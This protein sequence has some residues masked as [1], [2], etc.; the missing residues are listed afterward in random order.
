M[1]TLLHLL[2]APNELL[3]LL[4]RIP[5]STIDALQRR[6]VALPAPIRASDREELVRA[7]LSS[8]LH[9]WPSTEIL[10]FAVCVGGHTRYWMP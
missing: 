1:V 8:A 7:N 2:T 10:E 5:S 9:V 6:S 3:Q 4:L